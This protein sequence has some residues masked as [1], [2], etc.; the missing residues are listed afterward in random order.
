MLGAI[1][2]DVIGSIYEFNNIKSTVFPLF[3][4]KSDF[5]DDTVLTVATADCILNNEDYS[6]LYRKYYRKYPNR[7]YGGRFHKWGS[8]DSLV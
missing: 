1:A 2:G 3:T 7:G 8:S 5:T 6:V 4:D